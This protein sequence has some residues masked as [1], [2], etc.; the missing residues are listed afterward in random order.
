MPSCLVPHDFTE[1]HRQLE[2]AV[3]KLEQATDPICEKASCRNTFAAQGGGSP[4]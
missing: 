3:A 4:E 2:E 1:V